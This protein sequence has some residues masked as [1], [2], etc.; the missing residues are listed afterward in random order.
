MH[1]FADKK[2]SR[3]WIVKRRCLHAFF[4][5]K[6][7][8][9]PYYFLT[10]WKQKPHRSYRCS[11]PAVVTFIHSLD[12]LQTAI[13]CLSTRFNW[14]LCDEKMFFLTTACA[15]RPPRKQ[16]PTAVP[17]LYS[18]GNVYVWINSQHILIL[19]SFKW[20]S[21]HTHTKTAPQKKGSFR[22]SRSLHEKKGLIFVSL[23]HLLISHIRKFSM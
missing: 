6:C 22:E 13:Q 15:A 10:I 14:K 7:L 11:A 20:Q 5:A 19:C 21:T 18:F 1:S 23:E 4:S 8:C 3:A 2:G 16:K 12:T 17:P 9:A